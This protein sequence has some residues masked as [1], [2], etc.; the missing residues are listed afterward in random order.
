MYIYI[1]MFFPWL[2][3]YVFFEKS[4]TPLDKHDQSYCTTKNTAY[5][6]SLLYAVNGKPKPVNSKHPLSIPS[7]QTHIDAENPPIV[8]HYP[9][10]IIWLFH[11]LLY[12]YLRKIPMKCPVKS[13]KIQ[14]MISPYG[15]S[16]SKPFQLRPGP[17]G[18]PKYLK[19]RAWAS[20]RYML[21]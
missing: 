10:E 11:I 14:P 19:C 9:K 2:R 17:W 18:A 20:P 16:G 12:V 8:D 4:Q 7:L 13:H 21:V 6:I 15:P 5:T 3:V 1:Y